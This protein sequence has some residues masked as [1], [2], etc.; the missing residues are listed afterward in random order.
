MMQ[1]WADLIDQMAKAESNVTP[2]KRSKVAA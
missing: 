1:A 2:I